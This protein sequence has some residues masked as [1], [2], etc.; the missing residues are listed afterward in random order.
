MMDIQPCAPHAQNAFHFLPASIRL[1]S[2][3]QRDV[4][5]RVIMWTPLFPGV[6]FFRSFFSDAHHRL[7][8][9]RAL[10]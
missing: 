5:P 1:S 4:V 2:T 6:S 9:E 10:A 8:D 3:Q 7:K